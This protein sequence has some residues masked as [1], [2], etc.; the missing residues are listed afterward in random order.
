MGRTRTHVRRSFWP[1][2][3]S[4]IVARLQWDSDAIDLAPDAAT[5]SGL[6]DERRAR[7]TTLLTASA[8]RSRP[9]PSS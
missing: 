8:S 7:L 2:F 3:F 5:W 9:W 1:N 6:P 4:R